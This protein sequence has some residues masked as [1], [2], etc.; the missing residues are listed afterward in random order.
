MDVSIPSVHRAA[1]LTVAK[2]WKSW[3]TRLVTEFVHQ[4]KSPS[5]L[6]SCIREGEWVEF[7]KMKSTPEF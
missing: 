6:Y 5:S 1:L 7:V 2:A 4:G 3:K